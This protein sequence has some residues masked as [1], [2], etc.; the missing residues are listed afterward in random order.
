VPSF[1]FSESALEKIVKDTQIHDEI[2]GRRMRPLLLQYAECYSTDE[3]TGKR[4]DYGPG[5]TL[6][7]RPADQ[8]IESRYFEVRAGPHL[9]VFVSPLPYALSGAWMVDYADRAFVLTQMA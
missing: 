3:T 8:Q 5:F 7:F 2:H 1:S 9:T 6:H 4:I